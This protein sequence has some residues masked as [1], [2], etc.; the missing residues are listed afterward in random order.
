[1]PIR[2][3]VTPLSATVGK[4]ITTI[5]GLSPRGNHPVQ[6]WTSKQPGQVARKDDD[7]ERTLAAAGC[8]L[9]VAY[10]VRFLEHACM[11]PMNATAHVT[12]DACVAWAPTQNPGGAQAAARITGL[13]ARRSP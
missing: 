1:V 13:P 10:E 12:P 4:R 2:A 7:A 9:E 3:C 6:R 11:E 5:E 8:T